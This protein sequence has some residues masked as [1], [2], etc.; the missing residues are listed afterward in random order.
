MGNIQH[1]FSEYILNMYEQNGA[2][3]VCNNLRDPVDSL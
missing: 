2:G 3:N 1:W